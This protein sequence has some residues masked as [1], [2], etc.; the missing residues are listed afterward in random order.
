MTQNAKRKWFIPELVEAFAQ[1][2]AAKKE[3]RTA[4][5]A[6]QMA[7]QEFAETKAFLARIAEADK[8]R[9]P[10]LRHRKLR[11][12]SESTRPVLRRRLH[13]DSRL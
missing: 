9:D 8:I 10:E 12:I 7:R 4:E 3:A 2:R 13:S 5:R 6:I 11:D 1:L